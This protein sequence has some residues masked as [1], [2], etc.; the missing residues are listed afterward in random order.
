MQ[1]FPTKAKNVMALEVPGDKDMNAV[2]V[3]IDPAAAEPF[4]TAVLPNPALSN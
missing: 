2:T 1:P 4:V 3:T